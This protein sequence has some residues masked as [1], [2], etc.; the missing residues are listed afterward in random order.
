MYQI[1]KLLCSNVSDE[2]VYR[3][4]EDFWQLFIW[5]GIDT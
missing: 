3:M 1:Q 2:I 5:L 4:E